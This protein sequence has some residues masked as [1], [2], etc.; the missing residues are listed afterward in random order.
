M[1]IAGFLLAIGASFTDSVILTNLGLIDF[2]HEGT[3]VYIVLSLLK[4]IGSV[5]FENLPFIFVMSVAIGF[6]NSQKG[7][8]AIS[9][10]ISFIVMH[11]TISFLLVLSGVVTSAGEIAAGVPDGMVTTILGFQSLQVG[12]FGGILLGWAVAQLNNRFN[13]IK[14]PEV[15][16]FFEGSKFVPIISLFFSIFLGVLFFFIWPPIQGGILNLGVIISD[17][18]VMGAFLF[19][20][21]KRLLIPFGLHHVF[22]LLFW[23]TSLGGTEVIN[24][25]TY[26]GAQ[27]IYFAQLAD[28]SITHISASVTQYFGGEFAPMIFGLPAGVYAIYR[29]TA[30]EHKKSIKSIMQSSVLTSAVVGITEPIEFQIIPVAPL[31]FVFHA[32]MCGIC[33]AL[34][35]SLNFAVGCTFSSGLL[36]LVF[37]GILPGADRT[38]WHIIIPIGVAMA[39]IYYVVFTLTI[40]K[41]N[42]KFS[43]YGNVVDDEKRVELIVEGLGGIDNIKDYSSCA[44]RLRCTVTNPDLVD[45]DVLNETQALHIQNNGTAVQL[46]FGTKVT[47]IKSQIDNYIGD[48]DYSKLSQINAVEIKSPLAGEVIPLNQV[49]DNIFASGIMGDGIAVIPSDGE[50]RAPDDGKIIFLAPTN[51]AL[52]FLCDNGISLLIHIGI[53]TV[54]LDGK[55][56]ESLIDVDIPVTKG[57][58]LLKMD[59]E[60]IESQGL[61]TISPICVEL[62][63]NE[64]VTRKTDLKTVNYHDNIFYVEEK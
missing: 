1:P 59:L 64:I 9:S 35:L 12:V 33:N 13:E 11:E 21:I 7:I 14:L 19:S 49:P 60:Y 36:D 57:T 34:Q 37:L 17:A 51:H 2:I 18:G 47:L 42:V 46:I 50:V 43:N 20:T 48:A 8:A 54:K 15:F 27:N 16:S 4:N 5:I 23:Q 24:G 41:F 38:S 52:G 30:K 56:F 28:P 22:Y 62:T 6:S 45:E 31:L 61:S 32:I 10:V 25:I 29:H 44:T 40:T 55:G 3:P 39:I 58:T 26:V 63:E 53:D